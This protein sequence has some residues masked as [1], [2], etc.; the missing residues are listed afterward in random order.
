MGF[1][2][3]RLGQAQGLVGFQIRNSDLLSY[4]NDV[5]RKLTAM[6]YMGFLDVC[7]YVCLE[8]FPNYSIKI[9]F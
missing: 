9:N 3:L 2:V 8:I 4:N 5:M 7:V 1:Q 6:E